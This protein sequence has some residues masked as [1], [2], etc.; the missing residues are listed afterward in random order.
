MGLC[1]GPVTFTCDPPLVHPGPTLL[2]AGF[3]AFPL[4]DIIIFGHGFL[5]PI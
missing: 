2:A 3:P 4:E 1:L 5:S